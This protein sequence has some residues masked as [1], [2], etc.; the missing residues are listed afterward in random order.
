MLVVSFKKSDIR[1]ALE[2]IGS[3]I[4]AI[5]QMALLASPRLP[6]GRGQ[7]PE[8]LTDSTLETNGRRQIRAAH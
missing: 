3:V 7:G 6:C 8:L 5:G 1:L 2:A 4:R